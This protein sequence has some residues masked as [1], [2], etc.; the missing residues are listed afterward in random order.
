VLL[1]SV[2]TVLLRRGA[3]LGLAFKAYERG[4]R[5]PRGV[6]RRQG[7]GRRGVAVFLYK[8]ARG[9][10]PAHGLVVE[11]YDAAR[12][13]LELRTGEIIAVYLFKII[14]PCSWIG[15]FSRVYI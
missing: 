4:Q 1:I 11:A 13:R 10:A 7:R 5:R 2:F 6:A 3:R 8:R 12:F 14:Y 15:V 9:E